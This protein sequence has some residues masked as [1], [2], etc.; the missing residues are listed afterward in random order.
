MEI[1]NHSTI[2]SRQKISSPMSSWTFMMLPLPL[3]RH[4]LITM[5]AGRI[6]PL[7][8]LGEDQEEVSER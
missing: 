1:L 8:I 5:N 3:A 7:I 6:H 4:S 2:Q